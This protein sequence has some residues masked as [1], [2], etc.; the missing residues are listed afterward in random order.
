LLLL[1]SSSS[2][3]PLRN[4]GIEEGR[5]VPTLDWHQTL[6]NVDA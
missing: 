3:S 5:S 6:L 2:G 1:S 4:I